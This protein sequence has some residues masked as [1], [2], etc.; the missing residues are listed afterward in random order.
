MAE[1]AGSVADVHVCVPWTGYADRIQEVHIRCI[2][3]W[4][5]AIETAV[6]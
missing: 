4:I 6:A 2:H 1:L 3:S 5:D